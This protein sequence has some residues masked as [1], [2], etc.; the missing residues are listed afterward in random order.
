M[1]AEVRV[2]VTSPCSTKH[3]IMKTYSRV[4][5]QLHTLTLALDGSE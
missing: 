4:E 1:N 3:N 2:K 5:V